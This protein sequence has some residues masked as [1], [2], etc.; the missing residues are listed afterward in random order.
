MAFDLGQGDEQP[1]S[2][3]IMGSTARLHAFRRLRAWFGTRKKP[4]I[5]FSSY[6]NARGAVDMAGIFPGH[7]VIGW[8]AALRPQFGGMLSQ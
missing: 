1:H 4:L 3:L 2:V 5:R 8:L 7:T 6:S